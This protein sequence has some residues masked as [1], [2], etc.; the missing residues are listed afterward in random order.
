MFSLFARASTSGNST[1][2]P[3]TL[4]GHQRRTEFAHYLLSMPERKL[5]RDSA[6]FEMY[7]DDNPVA[8]LRQFAPQLPMRRILFDRCPFNVDLKANDLLNASTGLETKDLTC[9]YLTPCHQPLQIWTKH[10]SK[11]HAFYVCP[12]VDR[13]DFPKALASTSN[14]MFGIKYA[15]E[16]SQTRLRGFMVVPAWDGS[17]FACMYLMTVTG[18]A[19]ILEPW[20][21]EVHVFH[22]VSPQRAHL[23][24]DS[25]NF[26]EG[27]VSDMPM[28]ALFLDSSKSSQ[29]PI[30]FHD[31]HLGSRPVNWEY[32]K[33]QT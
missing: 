23:R 22:Q 31:H 8:D 32:Y 33:K 20:I 5:N 28:V 6:K 21:S 19:I 9:S 16:Q 17:V 25:I 2:L 10:V 7:S 13:K 1:A 15:L 27:Y 14:W 29:D 18:P 30:S 4:H 26:S 3:P 12:Y 24:K 11:D